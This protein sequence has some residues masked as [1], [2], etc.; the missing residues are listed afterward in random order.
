MKSKVSVGF[1]IK[2]MKD[3]HHISHVNLTFPNVRY[4]RFFIYLFLC[5]YL[6]CEIAWCII[7][8]ILCRHLH[9]LPKRN[10]LCCIVFGVFYRYYVDTY[11]TLV[12]TNTFVRI[13]GI[14]HKAGLTQTYITSLGVLTTMF[15]GVE[16]TLINVWVK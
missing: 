12:L 5:L 10:S 1:R 11:T 15:T 14:Y 6:I 13:L 16:R 4:V 8:L 3:Y 7:G 2:H 9:Q